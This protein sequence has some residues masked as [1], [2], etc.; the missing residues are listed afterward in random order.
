MKKLSDI[1]TITETK[2]SKNQIVVNIDIEGYN[3]IISF[4]R[5]AVE[6]LVA[7]V[8]TLKIL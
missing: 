7:L 1:I 2:L 3:T 6:E 4:T 8:Y 5:I